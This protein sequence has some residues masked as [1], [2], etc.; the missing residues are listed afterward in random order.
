MKLESLTAFG[1]AFVKLGMT[2]PERPE[3]IPGPPPSNAAQPGDFETM[4]R[5]KWKQTL[6][7]VPLSILAMGVGFGV[8]KTIADVAGER[9]ARSGSQPGWLKAVPMGLAAAGGASVFARTMV[10]DRLR[11]RREA[12][13]AAAKR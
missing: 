1:D 10:R 5:A 3:T 8:G 6:K 13:E 12:A 9:L 4:T 11:A 7:D 2:M